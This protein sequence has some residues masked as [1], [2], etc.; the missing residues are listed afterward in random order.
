MNK[1]IKRL[2]LIAI[3][4]L[5]TVAFMY[6]A[7]EIKVQLG[8]S[9][10]VNSVAFSPD[11]KTIASGSR[12]T[13]MK[14]W[15]VSTGKLIYSTIATPEGDSLRWIPEGYFSGSVKLA[16]K[17]VYMVDGMNIISIDQFFDTYYRPDIVAAKIK[18]E[19][20]SKYATDLD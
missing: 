8:H 3:L 1:Q 14:V 7:R 5:N 20:I 2:I 17:V 12:D 11:G 15:S 13:T 4:C 6:A 18:G 16:I 19:D 10:W 9:S